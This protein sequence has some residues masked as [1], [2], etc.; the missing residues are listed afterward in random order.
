[1]YYL[2]SSSEGFYS[3]RL[4]HLLE[5]VVDLSNQLGLDFRRTTEN[6]HG[7]RT[8]PKSEVSDLLR[9]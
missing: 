5:G 2:S 1:M 6:G 8:H 4:V 7:V 9:R 3:L